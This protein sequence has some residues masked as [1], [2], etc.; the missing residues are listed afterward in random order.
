MGWLFYEFA[1]STAVR[2]RVRIRILADFLRARKFPDFLAVFLAAFP[3]LQYAD[4]SKQHYRFQLIKH[5]QTRKDDLTFFLRKMQ[6]SE[7]WEPNP[8]LETVLFGNAM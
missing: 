6:H 2:L 8:D 7:P 1:R 5:V 4:F 3:S